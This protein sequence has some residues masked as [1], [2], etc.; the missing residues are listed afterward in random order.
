M[1][2]FMRDRT[3]FLEHCR[4]EQGDVVHLRFGPHRALLINR[5][6][7][8][9][10]VLVA[11]VETFPKLFVLRNRLRPDK[12]A[13]PAQ[14][15]WPRPALA[16]SV[17]HR[18]QL[19]SYSATVT[20]AAAEMLANWHD[21]DTRDIL[22]D[23]LATTLTVVVRTLFG[24]DVS[25]RIPALQSAMNDMLAEL[26]QR[27]NW[28]LLLPD[29][30]PTRTNRRAKAGMR[31]VDELLE[32]LIPDG[33]A[34]RPAAAPLPAMLHA[35]AAERAIDYAEARREA[36]AMAVA[37]H[38]SSG[39]ALA[40][41][42]YLMARHPEVAGRVEAEVDAAL[43]GRIPT[44]ESRQRLPYTEMVIQETLRL[45]PPVW[46]MTRR[47]A[48]RTTLAGEHL[49]AGTLVLVSQWLAHR[50]AEYFPAP[51]CFQPDRWANGLSRRLPHYAYFP[52]SGGP[53]V[54]PGS[55]FAMHE[56]MLIV[57]MIVQHARLSLVPNR[58]VTLSPT[59]TLRPEHGIQ[60]VITRH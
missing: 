25:A 50:N 13:E 5:P 38:E 58:P 51:E 20:D 42:M 60:M 10:R 39:L 15:Y 31:F 16:R 27:L 7:D 45:Y 21:G 30:L 37:G 17:F 24:A 19:A 22:P 40:W 11:D 57:P 12:T 14:H 28:M 6:D 36:L 18:N 59:F 32:E 2:A 47:A 55:T 54:C 43:G 53:R 9:E 23:V 46:I 48:Q 33:L 56:L 41:F 52:F 1:P 8:I 44:A 3:G 4:R 26:V 34:D 35:A 29:W 49:P